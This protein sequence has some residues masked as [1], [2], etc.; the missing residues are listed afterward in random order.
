MG[1]M[2][3]VTAAVAAADGPTGQ[4]GPSYRLSSV[5][6]KP[7]VIWGAECRQPAG[8]GVAFGGQ[9]QQAE[10]LFRDLRRDLSNAHFEADSIDQLAA[11]IGVEART[12]NGFTRTGGGA[13]G[14]D[15]EIVNTVFDE[16]TLS[17]E[18]MSDVIE[19][20]G[21]RT[22][23]L[24]VVAHNPAT[25]QSLDDVRD[26]VIASLREQQT[27]TLL[28]AR[29]DRM[30]DAL[31]GGADFADAAVAVGAA[32]GEPVVMTR[33]SQDVD[34][35]VSVAVFTAVKPTEENPTVG[36]TRNAAGGYTVY[37]VEAVLP[38][39]PE[40]LNVEERDAGK[41]RLTDQTGVGEF[42]AFVQALRDNAEVIINEDA[43][44]G[45]DML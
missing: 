23:V 26:E 1:N 3:D 30:I 43:V 27:E 33:S 34:P 21:D 39:R 7:R 5:D 37:S 40:G 25:R 18:Q 4:T 6:L 38:G 41:A 31:H 24:Q 12:E 28:A 2:R 15:A 13:L 42:V 10:D 9:D 14:T 11:A 45:S 36:S 22:V 19:V 20:D 16:F 8:E 32:A 29:A 44:A 35:Y 17:G